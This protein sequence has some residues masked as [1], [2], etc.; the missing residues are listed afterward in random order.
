MLLVEILFAIVMLAAGLLALAAATGNA[1]R[2]RYYSRSDVE[3]W[4]AV[5]SQA[6]SLSSQGY[7][8]LIDGSATVQ[9]HPMNWTVT[10]AGLKT[11]VLRWER[12]SQTGQAA[13]ADSLVMYL[14]PNTP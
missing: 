13:I 4:A 8:N 11:V 7:A 6:D 5:H 9:G 3:L 2:M 1:A 10:G 12:P 14:R